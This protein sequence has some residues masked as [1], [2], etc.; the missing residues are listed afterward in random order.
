MDPDTRTRALVMERA[1]RAR[2]TAA[3]LIALSTENRRVAREL[4]SR[5]HELCGDVTTERLDVD[6]SIRRDVRTL[7]HTRLRLAHLHA[8]RRAEPAWDVSREPAHPVHS[9]PAY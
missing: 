8:R 5:S 6:E 1:R 7:V 3:Q 9:H 4:W 2:R